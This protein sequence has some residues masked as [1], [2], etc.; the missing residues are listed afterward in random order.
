MVA[1]KESQLKILLELGIKTVKKPSSDVAFIT[2]AWYAEERLK[3]YP[4]LIR[5]IKQN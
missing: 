3:H 5:N 4:S 2:K 1:I